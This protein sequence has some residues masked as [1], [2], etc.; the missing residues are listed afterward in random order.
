[1]TPLVLL[2]GMNCTADLWTGC[3]V[4]DAVTPAL[5][6]TAMRPQ[7]E[8]L[9][10]RLP[11]RFVLGGLSLGAIVAMALAIRAPHRV[12]GLVLISTN[13]KAPTAPQQNG[14]REWIARLD[15]GSTARQ[16]QEGILDSLLSPRTLQDRPDIVERTLAMGDAT[17]PAVLRTQLG[18][19]ATRVD[20]RPGLR[21]LDIPALI[22]AGADD[23]ICPPEFHAEIAAELP[24]ARL[25]TTAG[26]H[27]LPLERPTAIG[28]MIHKWRTRLDES[29][30]LHRSPS[31]FA[32]R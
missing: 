6:E 13:A 20:L 11:Q 30:H 23:V 26:A 32:R 3:G 8:A 9:L 21:G 16:L 1:M 5:T 19:Q 14:W 29:A 7:V 24:N 2:P 22:I 15:A 4:D 27:L 17:G 31:G 25:V 28:A 12:E 10:E 18:M